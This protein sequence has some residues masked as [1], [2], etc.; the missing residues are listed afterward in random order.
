MAEDVDPGSPTLTGYDGVLLTALI[1]LGGPD[2]RAVTVPEIRSEADLLNVTATTLT[3]AAIGLNRLVH[4]GWASVVPGELVSIA[5]TSK[6]VGL[7]HYG[8]RQFD[9]VHEVLVAIGGD[10]YLG[11]EDEDRSLGL[12][13]G[14][15][16]EAADRAEQAQ[17]GW[18]QRIPPEAFAAFEAVRDQQLR[19][20]GRPVADPRW[21]DLDDDEGGDAGHR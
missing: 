16:W 12:L 4:A 10:R 13:D 17:G 1:L 14:V 6:A 15:D 2:G 3:Q 7:F 8:I 21:G 5:P 18:Q 9:L 11:A 19:A 20:K